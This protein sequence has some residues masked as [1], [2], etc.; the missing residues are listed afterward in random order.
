MGT[1]NVPQTTAF[2]A[3]V[4]INDARVPNI[5]D[6][7]VSVTMTDQNLADLHLKL[8][9]PQVDSSSVQTGPTM[10]A[11]T[12]QATPA[13]TTGLFAGG[14]AL[15]SVNGFYNGLLLT[16]TS[17]MNAGQS[18][19]VTTY[20]GTTKVFT[21]ATAWANAPAAGDA[22][23]MPGPSINSFAGGASLSSID[24]FYDGLALTFTSGPNQGQTRTVATY[25]GTTKVFTFTFPWANSPVPGDTFVLSNAAI[26]LVNNKVTP[27]GTSRMGIG[28]N[29]MALGVGNGVAVGTVFDDEAVRFIT[30]MGAVT[31]FIGHFRPEGTFDDVGTLSSFANVP[32]SQVNGTWTLL[33]TDNRNEPNP[34]TPFFLQ[35]WFLNFSAGMTLGRQSTIASTHVRGANVLPYP[36]LEGTLTPNVSP[37]IGIGPG[38]V[39]AQNN[40]LGSFSPYQGRI[41]VSFVAHDIFQGNPADNTYI[42]LYYSDD[43]GLS[44][45]QGN[46]GRPVNDDSLFD[47]FSEGNRPIFEPAIAVDQ[48]TGTLVMSFLDTRNDPARARYAT[49]LA[50]SI[51]GGNSFAPET[52]VN[53]A[54]KA[55]DVI[56]GNNVTL[57]PIPDNVSTGNANR[58]KTFGMGFHQALAV[59]AGHVYPIWAGNFNGNNLL[60]GATSVERSKTDILM[61][62]VEIAAGPRI[63]SGTMG[64]VQSQ[65]VDGFTFNNQTTTDGLPLV[66]GFAVSFDR[67]VDPTTFTASAVTVFYRDTVTPVSQQGTLVTVN[68][69]VALG[70][71]SF[72]QG[73]LPPTVNSFAGDPSLA[74]KDGF[75]NGFTLTF[76][77]GVNNGQ[78]RTV[79]AYIGPSNLFTFSTPW[80]VAPSAGDTFTVQNAHSSMDFFVPFQT[81]QTGRGTYSYSVGP[82]IKD[83]I[84]TQQVVVTPGLPQQFNTAIIN[85]SIPDTG[86]IDNTITVSAFPPNAI[87]TNV[88]VTVNI[89][90]TQDAD[91]TLTLIAPDGTPV[92]LVAQPGSPTDPTNQNFTNTTFAD[93]F[94]S[95]NSTT[96]P[97]TGIFSPVQALSNFIGKSP[98]GIWTLEVNDCCPLDA[99]TL[100]NWSLRITPGFNNGLTPI[101]GNLMDQNGNAVTGEGASSTSSGDIFAIPTPINHPPFQLPY[102]QDTL[103]IIV[104]G[105]HIVNTFVPGQPVTSDNLVLNGTNNAID[106]VFDRDMDPS[107]FTTA[108]ASLEILRMMGPA[109]QITGPFTITPNP[110]GTDPDPMHPRTFRIG[111]PTQQLSGT[112]TVTLAPVI[113][114]KA[115]PGQTVGDLLDTNLNAG[116]DVLRGIAVNPA[117]ASITPVSHSYAGPPVTIAPGKS[118]S[119]PINFGPENFVITSGNGS[120]LQSTSVQLN[121]TYPNDPD[122]ELFLVAPDGTTVKLFSNFGASLPPPHANFTNTVFNDNAST[123]IQSGVPPYNSS[124]AGPFDPQTPLSV[125]NGKAAAG[126]YQLVVKNDAT[127]VTGTHTLNSWSITLWESVPGTGLGE[128]VADQATAHF[129]IFTMD[130]QNPLAHNVWTA[131][132]PASNNSGFNSGRI[133]GLAVDPSD[134]SGNTVYVA[135]ASGGVWKTTNFL[136]TDPNGPTYIPLTDF[137]PTFAINIGSIAVFG[138]NNDPNQSILFA[139][140]GEGDTSAVG[141]ANPGASGN[142][143]MGVGVIRSMDGGA[144]WTLLDSTINVDGSGNPLPINSPMRD[145]MFVGTT[146]FKVVVDPV[147]APSGPNDVV[148]YMALGGSATSGGL[149]RSLDSGKHWTRMTDTTSNS[150]SAIATDVVLAPASALNGSGN[151]Q[152]VYAAFE[153]V[154]VYKSVSEG[155]NLTLMAGGAGNGTIRDG[156]FS[157]ATTIPVNNDAQSPNGANGRIVLATLAAG[158]APFLSGLTG[159]PIQDL[160]YEGW[161]WAAVVTTGG[162]LKGLYITKD[163]GGNWTQIHLP[164]SPPDI[165]H[166]FGA[167]TNDESKP[168]FNPLGFTVSGQSFGQGNYDVS[169]TLDPTNPNIAYLGGTEDFQLQ[170]A[171]GLIRVDATKLIDPHNMTAFDNDNPDGGLLERSTTGAVNLKMPLMKDVYGLL[172]PPLLISVDPRHFLNLLTDPNAQFL[173]N[174]TLELTQVAAFNNNGF[175]A[176]WGPFDGVSGTTDQHR[177]VAFKDPLTGHARLIFGDD[178]GV[179]SVVDHGDGTLDFG[180]G[181]APAA[182]GPRNGNLQ[183]TQFYYGAAQPSILAA[184]IGA[185]LF[186]GNAQD[187]GFP[188]SDPNILNDGNIGWNGPTGDGSGIA[189]DQTGSGTAYSYQWPCCGEQSQAATNFFLVAPNGP[190]YISRTG[191]ASGFSLVQQNL[192][193]PVPDPQWPYLAGGAGRGEVQSNFAVNPIN[194]NAIIIGSNAGR[195]FRTLDQGKTWGVIGDPLSTTLTNFNGTP[196]TTLAFDGTNIPALAFGA[197]D[198]ANP[199]NSTNDFMYVGTTGGRLLMTLDGGGHWFNL[200]TDGTHSLDGSPVM[201]ISANPTRGMHEIYLVTTNGVYRVTFKAT[202]PVNASPQISNVVLTNITGNV[203]NLTGY[204][205][206]INPPA[207]GTTV[208]GEQKPLNYLTAI[209]ADWRFQVPPTVPTTGFFHPY[210]YIGG[211][212]GVFRSTNEDSTSPTWTIFPSIADGSPVNG[213]YLP[214]AHVTDLDLAVGNVNPTNGKPDQSFGFNMLV[215]TTYGR[216]TFAIR[217]PNN[218]P[219]NQFSGPQVQSLLPDP[220]HH[221]D[222]AGTLSAVKVTFKGA[223][224]PATFT[225]QDIDSFLG[226]NGNSIAILTIDN[227]T[228]APAPGQPP[229]P[230]VFDLNFAPQTTA[231]VYAIT[232]G[233]NIADFAGNLMDQDG[234]TGTNGEANG[235]PDDIYSGRFFLNGTASG[236]F[237]PA[238]V[239]HDPGTGQLRVAISNGNNAFNDSI[240]GALGTSATWVD[241]VTGDFNGDGKTDIAA[242][243]LQTGQIWVGINTGN[244]FAF[245]LWT[246][247][248][249]AVTWVDVKVGDFNGDGKDDIIGRYLQ[250]GQWWV[251]SSLGNSFN[252][253]LWA[254]WSTAATWV[255]TQVGDFNGAINPGT[256]KRIMDITSRWLQGGS[257]WT[258]ISTGNSF[259]TT[260]WAQWSTVPTWVDV[261]VGDFNGDGMDDITARYKEAGAWWTGISTGNSFDTGSQPWAQWSPNVTWADVRVGDFNG[262]GKADIVGRWLE[263]GV[264]FAGISTGTSFASPAVWAQWSTAV[265]WQN[266]V[267]GDFNGDGKTD[268]AAMENNIW[269]TGISSGTG[270]VTNL[271]DSWPAA[272]W[273]DVQTMKST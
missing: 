250:A 173:A 236:P 62:R 94:P 68:N 206:N 29:G 32:S 197:P 195:L 16:F 230:S 5:T 208:V 105:P 271:W 122:L 19:T 165:P 69:P 26:T 80:S 79:T 38:I 178:Q 205:N 140:T 228:P 116:L 221:G 49:Y 129:R 132:G 150:P 25:N 251:A 86:T 39:V 7:D 223:V 159:S 248:S 226:P 6:L 207:S 210:L 264:W 266:V 127:S 126:V 74:G 138:R 151:L 90:H 198:P 87:V 243:W 56:T 262:D 46:Q 188:T 167:P 149:W 24:D 99:G 252:N 125:L 131:V 104:P 225:V 185:A 2:T 234:D 227:L 218:S 100:G 113:R 85:Q 179:Y 14:T 174:S 93:G 21:F 157:P 4:S 209:V 239:G 117:A 270:F 40:T 31:P 58:D 212:G 244:A 267:V 201:S 98:N 273:T 48:T 245:S 10:T 114:A 57:E 211:E 77:S 161:L 137:G 219:F 35:D 28:I 103:P 81:P 145:H 23:N 18:R 186:Y 45:T 118:I 92:T 213:G 162:G 71:P 61:A 144:T 43:G 12:V 216:G 148:V 192:P 75:Y 54:T 152:L 20:N 53:Q 172:L 60:Y 102:S 253:T 30:D 214:L 66:T 147:H 204:L 72:V 154:G 261:R 17:G 65:T 78:T 268:I 163:G 224:D 231:G 47:N 170:P 229:P 37:D 91:L 220:A 187:D 202:Y 50:T 255:D 84:R 203:F 254:T 52:F 194:G 101:N 42:V 139:T 95:I 263:A 143:S 242:R 193:G 153:G 156:D 247:W 107:T 13:P 249:S 256:G 63:V 180:I 175:D 171:S 136:T 120:L 109:G 97:Y 200:S 215:A 176:T 83:A 44:W 142:T 217:L 96:A 196:T 241:V 130:T 73:S 22:F 235:Q 89:T 108:N 258:G 182:S 146:S 115:Q 189:T 169:L 9:S 190:G 41:Y 257:W 3:S 15:S 222:P 269:W 11:S 232:L 233:P 246:T 55:T 112:Y 160:L 64:P 191:T 272:N 134:P 106:V 33:V 199:S 237:V 124:A 123:P 27:D 82:T 238:I 59:N 128:P 141:S 158:Q 67:P 181:T 177:V 110:N 111:F 70:T 34:M 168:D 1:P 88:R 133:G 121:I 8:L 183:I 119:V 164:V 265:T 240:F 76:T 184:Q 259:T 166:H 51:D 260:M 155:T 36:P 135:G